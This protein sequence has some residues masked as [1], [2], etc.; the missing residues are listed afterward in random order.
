MSR[1]KSTS[2]QGRDHE[3]AMVELFEFVN[4]RRS[5]SSGANPG[6]DTDVVSDLFSMECESTM[7]Q[8]YS[9]KK[10][11]WREVKNKSRAGRIPLL[12]IQFLDVDPRKTINLIVM[13]ADDVA[14]LLEKI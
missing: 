7:H 10:T 12:G 4:A 1:P 2:Q 13:S 9:L 14:E 11:F 8:S 6:D 5:N 3:E